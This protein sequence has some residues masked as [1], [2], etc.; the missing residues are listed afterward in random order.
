[1]YQAFA[2]ALV[3]G[4]SDTLPTAEDGLVAARI[5]RTATDQLVANHREAS[6]TE[7]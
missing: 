2:E 5:S 6:R 7:P 4:H 1:M 3:T